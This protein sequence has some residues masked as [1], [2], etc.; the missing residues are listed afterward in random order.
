MSIGSS[1]LLPAIGDPAFAV[2]NRCEPYSFEWKIAV[3]L[4]WI[5]Q[6]EIAGFVRNGDPPTNEDQFA[7]RE[8]PHWHDGT[9]H[10]AQVSGIGVIR[11]AQ[12]SDN[13]TSG[14]ARV[15]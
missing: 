5:E 11:T 8:F 12:F 7:A 3:Q 4:L 15:P 2:E 1:S 6:Q 9:H 10:A 14:E 13:I